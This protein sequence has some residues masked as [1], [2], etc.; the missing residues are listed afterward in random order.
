[1]RRDQTS[2]LCPVACV[3]GMSL[4]NPGGVPGARRYQNPCFFCHLE[5]VWSLYKTAPYWDTGDLGS[6]VSPGPTC[7]LTLSCC[8]ALWVEEGGCYLT[9]ISGSN[10]PGIYLSPGG[11]AQG[12]ELLG[13]SISLHCPFLQM[14]P[15]APVGILHLAGFYR[16]DTDSESL[17]TLL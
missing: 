7:W 1:M 4:N 16:A 15:P 9:V 6:S 5:T 8:H 3:M 11:S 10:T 17:Q 14:G 2:D 13:A 12:C